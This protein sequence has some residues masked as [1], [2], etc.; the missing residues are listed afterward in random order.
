MAA[1]PARMVVAP[2]NTTAQIEATLLVEQ[3][4][5]VHAA[6]VAEAL[7]REGVIVVQMRLAATSLMDLVLAMVL[8]RPVAWVVPTSR[9]TVPGQP[10]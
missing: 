10:V 4:S 6:A 5:K 8:N 9:R 7:P 1:M 3:V 2:V